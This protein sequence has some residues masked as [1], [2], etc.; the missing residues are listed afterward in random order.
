M[1]WRHDELL[2]TWNARHLPFLNTNSSSALQC[3][4]V[5]LPDYSIKMDSWLANEAPA[6]SQCSMWSSSSMNLA[7]L[8][9]ENMVS[10]SSALPFFMFSWA[11][12]ITRC[13]C[14]SP[15]ACLIIIIYTEWTCF[16]SC[17]L[18]LAHSCF[19][20]S[21]LDHCCQLLNHCHPQ[22]QWLQEP[23]HLNQNTC[24]NTSQL[25]SWMYEPPCICWQILVLQL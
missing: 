19:P 5:I 4:S 17:L 12:I 1:C 6:S 2:P 11:R 15:S 3:Q 23:H 16:R 10:R 7:D 22:S 24:E 20:H 13:Q 8:Q 21:R 18:C 9:S 14:S 25:I